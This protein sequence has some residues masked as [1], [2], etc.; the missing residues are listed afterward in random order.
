MAMP[1]D[2]G[3]KKVVI[4][5]SG[6]IRIGQAAEFDYSGSQ[7]LKAMREEHVE[8]VL[9][10]PN[11]ATIQ[12]SHD[13]ADKV[14]LEPVTPEFMEKVIR[15]ERPDGIILGFGGQTALNTGV[16]LSKK[17]VLKKYGVRVL[18]TSVKAIMRTEDREEFKE[19][20][21]EAGASVAPSIS[22]L[23]MDD[24]KAAA[25]KI[26]YPVMVRPAY[27]LGGLGSGAAWNEDELASIVRKGLRHSMIGQVLIEEYLHHWKEV[28]YEVMRDSNDN[29]ITVCNMENFDPM[30]VHTGDSIVVAP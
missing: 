10:N 14:Y 30:G 25:R 18:G 11:V 22:C 29:C 17:G 16:A 9:V 6:G 2:K 23:N 8:T 13:L 21:V 4:I 5:G 12:T 27:I 24:A 7:A 19:A 15:K 3:I 20:V 26:G 28:E 1:K